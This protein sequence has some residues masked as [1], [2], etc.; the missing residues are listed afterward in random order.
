MTDDLRPLGDELQDLAAD[1]TP[2]ASATNHA[3][4]RARR[5]ITR[6]RRNQRAAIAGLATVVIAVGATAA[7]AL[8][9]DA[10]RSAP[11]AHETTVEPTTTTSTVAPAPSE[12]PTTAPPAASP[13]HTSVPDWS[14]IPAAN[15]VYAQHFS[16][17]TGD[18]QVAFHTPQGEGASGGPSA[19][20]AD[21]AGN[22]VM[23]DHSNSRL[24]ASTRQAD[25]PIHIDGLTPAVTAAVFDSQG[26]VIVASVDALYVYGP[27][28]RPEGSWPHITNDAH[29][30]YEL[31]VDGAG[32]YWRH[33]G[34][35]AAQGGATRTALLRDDGS[36]YVAATDQSPEPDEITGR[37]DSNL[38]TLH[39]TATGFEYLITTTD[40]DV[41][42]ARAL[43]DGSF[44]FVL[45]RRQPGVGSPAL[46]T[47]VVGYIGRDGHARYSTI[48]APTGYLVNGPVFD[49]GDD[50]VAVMSSTI[51][52]GATVAYYQY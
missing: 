42:A 48:D 10:R 32:V 35:D 4:D 29:G 13:V 50:G 43:P 39:V 26:R 36:G 46:D 27:D 6:H 34:L 19:F 20:T 24:L 15:P 49:I 38:T 33:G 31:E 5:R 25:V 8:D 12:P 18:N 7:V 30:I 40:T 52:D 47:Y 28:G 44:V 45:G 3:R 9:R 2:T 51:A 22:V 14:T 21:G 23:L 1:V 17:G 16:W 37:I 11:P 41:R